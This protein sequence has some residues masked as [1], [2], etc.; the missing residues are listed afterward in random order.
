M[1]TF[2]FK[3]QYFPARHRNHGDFIYDIYKDPKNRLKYQDCKRLQAYNFT[4]YSIII[5]ESDSQLKTN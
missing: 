5:V 2:P 3:R 1:L 4:D